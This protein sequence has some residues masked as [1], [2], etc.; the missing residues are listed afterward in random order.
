[1]Y[2][3]HI[4]FAVLLLLFLGYCLLGLFFEISS[5]IVRG[6]RV[7]DRCRTHTLWHWELPQ[8][9]SN[10][11]GKRRCNLLTRPPLAIY[12]LRDHVW[13]EWSYNVLRPSQD[14]F[15][16]IQTR[17]RQFRDDSGNW[18]ARKTTDLGQSNLHTFSH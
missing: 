12:L 2:R 13:V 3:N 4:C 1:M 5:G 17:D 9:D 18:S 7:S 14:S 15:T 11:G 8:S 10:I 6:T 16:N